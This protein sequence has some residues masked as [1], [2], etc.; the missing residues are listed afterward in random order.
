MTPSLALLIGVLVLQE[1]PAQEVPDPETL[2]RVTRY[3]RLMFRD[4]ATPFLLRQEFIQADLVS[5]PVE[6]D[7]EAQGEQV[8]IEVC[9]PRRSG[10]AGQW[11]WPGH[12]LEE[13]RRQCTV[14]G[15]S[16]E[17]QP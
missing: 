16:D 9:R 6:L 7:E 15:T 10:V 5:S 13:R 14:H 4:A 11:L 2:L 8:V 12:S 3:H 1:P 17:R